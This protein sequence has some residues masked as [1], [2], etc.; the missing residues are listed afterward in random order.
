MTDD[1]DARELEALVATTDSLATGDREPEDLDGRVRVASSLLER[2][3]ALEV[4][5]RREDALVSYAAVAERFAADADSRLREYV[6]SALYE[7]SKLS[8]V[9]RRAGEAEEFADRLIGRARFASGASE[10]VLLIKGGLAKA[11]SLAM[12]GHNAHAL[13]VLDSLPGPASDSPE[14]TVALAGALRLKAEL[15]D[16]TGDR[17]E[18]LAARRQLIARF[19]E[20]SE[21]QVR[22]LV[23]LALFDNARWLYGTDR[24]AEALLAVE[25]LLERFSDV[26]PPKRPHL[27]A[28]ALLRKGIYLRELGRRDEAVSAFDAVCDTYGPGLRGVV[29]DAML[30]K[31]EILAG[32]G[33]LR[34]ALSVLDSLLANSHD[35][36]TV[37]ARLR[38][39]TTDALY[40]RGRRLV[41][42]GDVDEAIAAWGE[43]IRRH[44][45]DP[46]DAEPETVAH[47]R[48]NQIDALGDL[49]RIDD[50]IACIDELVAR[51]G[52][53][54]ALSARL[55]VSSALG[56][57]ATLF[58]ANGRFEEQVTALDELLQRFGDAPEPELRHTVAEALRMKSLRLLRL[59]RRDEAFVIRDALVSRFEKTGLLTEVAEA[60]LK[61]AAGLF[62]EEEL[63]GALGT[64]RVLLSSLKDSDEAELRSVAIRASGIMVVCLE[65]LG[66]LDEAEVAHDQFVAFGEEALALYDD[67]ARR[68]KQHPDPQRT[69]ELATV[70]V[71]RAILLAELGRREEALAAL[72]QVI[73][74]FGDVRAGPLAEIASIARDARGHILADG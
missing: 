57:K 64:A 43:A 53:E 22:A 10:A 12:R 8:A 26:T 7:A 50:A 42:L 16:R 11:V 71:R 39:A 13:Q 40:L 68:A 3:R 2:G 28:E 74:R 23:A 54:E 21:P 33:D 5:G 35:D 32:R 67:A 15:L 73:D 14:V 61:V 24:T 30:Y 56:R 31:S 18:A 48:S 59:G 66:R 63:E 34:G 65:K 4:L 44:L 55:L 60:V 6:D 52:D 36:A 70:S 62:E 19:R 58:A 29:A 49:G 51:Y 45:H 47:A 37:D 69:S 38:K 1:R 25:E 72:N 9:L 46:A 20:E 27:Q 41:E 17:E